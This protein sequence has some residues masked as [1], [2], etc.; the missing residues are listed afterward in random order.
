MEKHPALMQLQERVERAII[1]AGIPAET[2]RFSPHITL[3]R[4]RNSLP[5]EVCEWE[6]R[7]AAFRATVIPVDEFHLYSSVLTRDGAVHR[8]EAT[9][10]LTE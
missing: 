7:Q 2:R 8:R 10:P 1:A 3:A 4:L 9:Y 6:Q 5:A